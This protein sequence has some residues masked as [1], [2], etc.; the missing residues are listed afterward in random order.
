VLVNRGDEKM[1]DIQPLE[2]GVFLHS[3]AVPDLGG[4]ILAAG[5]DKYGLVQLGPVSDDFLI[6]D[7]VGEERSALVDA[8]QTARI[9]VG[10][11]CVC[12]EH[13]LQGRGGLEVYDS[14][15][16]IMRT[17]GYGYRGEDQE[18][19]VAERVQLTKDHIDLARYLQEE[20]VMVA[21]RAIV[22]THI[23]HIMGR[24]QR[25]QIG[26]AI[27]E[28]L[29]YCE[30]VDAYFAMETGTE[31]IG[32]VLYWIDAM[33]KES[34]IEGRFGIN[35]DPANL[36][37]YRA[38]D[39]LDAIY[40]L[41][42]EDKARYLFGVHVKDAINTGFGTTVGG[43]WHKDGGEVPVGTGSVPWI[44]LLR[45]IYALG[46]RGPLIIEREGQLPDEDDVPKSRRFDIDLARSV[47]AE[48]KR[49]IV[50]G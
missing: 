13:G 4:A 46:Y 16:A 31:E 9:K 38:Q 26:N 17:G 48:A 25:V 12:Y 34:G 24:D 33:E 22:T 5:Q 8:L 28:I 41:G 30:Q 3:L 44:P 10:P 11:M 40:E 18:R 47:I 45:K 20:G 32:E 42:R 37:Q 35:F 39:P 7:H 23:G 21:D 15:D 49:H 36:L 1:G 27:V 29:H 50:R 6:G 14:V 19:I 43:D 2:T